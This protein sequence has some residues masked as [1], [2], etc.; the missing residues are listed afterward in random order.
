[1]Q[2]ALYTPRRL[3]AVTVAGSPN[4]PIGRR[5]NGGQPVSS[6]SATNGRWEKRGAMSV[7]RYLS[8]LCTQFPVNERVGLP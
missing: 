5:R 1:M 2:I 7:S 6:D 8:L 4:A 3:Q